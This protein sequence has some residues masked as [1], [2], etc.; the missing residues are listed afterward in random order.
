METGYIW[1]MLKG[2]NTKEFV[3]FQ[4]KNTKL[5]W[6]AA[7]LFYFYF[8]FIFFN[9]TML[10]DV[11]TACVSWWQTQSLG[12]WYW[13]ISSS[14]PLLLMFSDDIFKSSHRKCCII[15]SP[16]KIHVSVGKKERGL[17]NN[18]LCN[19]FPRYLCCFSTNNPF[20]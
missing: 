4:L 12:F 20:K 15:L 3:L 6:K 8:F 13:N 11:S 2:K 9:D 17:T 19:F 1:K 10:A 7:Q 16:H 14:Y 5:I 18:D